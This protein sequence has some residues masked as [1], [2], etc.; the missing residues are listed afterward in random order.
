MLS[1]VTSDLSITISE[2]FESRRVRK[3]VPETSSVASKSSLFSKSKDMNSAK[4]VSRQL[5]ADLSTEKEDTITTIYDRNARAPY[6]F[7][8]RQH[9]PELEDTIDELEAQPDSDVQENLAKDKSTDMM[10]SS[11][12]TGYGLNPRLLTLRPAKAQFGLSFGADDENSLSGV[13]RHR[14]ERSRK[15]ELAMLPSEDSGIL[16]DSLPEPSPDYLKPE[17]DDSALNPFLASLNSFRA[18]FGL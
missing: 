8:T 14:S 5:S 15:A 7:L 17:L 13:N 9:I 3:S 4:N 10:A 18:Q 2:S 6:S 16:E 1:P 11:S 12:F